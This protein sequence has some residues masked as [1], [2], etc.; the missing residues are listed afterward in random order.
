MTRA[1]LAAMLAAA[2][3][4]ASY[5]H[6][7]EPPEQLAVGQSMIVAPGS[8]YVDWSTLGQRAWHATISLWVPRSAG[9]VAMDEIDAGLV[10]L[11]AVLDAE[12]DLGISTVRQVG[13]ADDVGGANYVVALLDVDLDP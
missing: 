13:S 9:P 12:P 4:L 6:Y 1:E 11:L 10:A 5:T 8:P 3:S 2:P 7:P